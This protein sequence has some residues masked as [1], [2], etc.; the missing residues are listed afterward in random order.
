MVTRS[1]GVTNAAGV[2]VSEEAAQGPI[3]P[4]NFGTAGFVGV[5]ERGA[6]GSLLKMLGPKSVKRKVG[7]RLTGT[8]APDAVQD[9]W[10]RSSGAGIGLAVRV[11]D[12]AEE[13]AG[14]KLFGRGYGAGFIAPTTEKDN[15]SQVRIPV[16]QLTAKDGGRWAGRR[17]RISGDITI[18]SALTETTLATGVAMAKN[19]WAGATVLLRGDHTTSAAK[20]YT[21]LTN[22]VAGV[23]T[24]KSDSTM[25]TDATT[26]GVQT[27]VDYEVILDNDVLASGRRKGLSVRV[28]DG[29]KDPANEFG[30]DVYLDGEKIHGWTDL[31][32]D[33]TASNYAVDV[34][35]D[36]DSN[37]E[38]DATDL[39]PNGTSIVPDV[40]PANYYGMTVAATATK[41]TVN[42]FQIAQNDAPTKIKIASATAHAAAISGAVALVPLRLTFT[43]VAA[44]NYYTVAVSATSQDDVEV[45]NLPN[46][47]IAAAPKYNQTYTSSHPWLPIVTVDHDA[48]PTDGDQFAIDVF[49]P[50]A[51][52][53]GGLVYPDKTGAQFT[54]LAIGSV[55]YNSITVE[56]G[57]P[58]ATA[59]AATVASVTGTADE[60]FNITLGVDDAVS[61]IIDGRDQVDVTLTAGATQT[62]ADVVADIN[63]AFDAVFGAGVLNPASVSGTK[64]LLTSPG[65]FDGG[66]PGSSVE[67]VTV[68]ADAYT[69]LGLTV[70][71]TYGA[72]GTEVE[73]QYLQQASGGYDGDVPDL[74]DFLDAF[75][76]LTSPFNT[77]AEEGYGVVSILCPGIT[78]ILSAGDSATVHQRA[79]TYCETKPYQYFVE[80]PKSKTDEA[81][82]LTY[83]NTTVGRSDMAAC[84]VPS[85]AYAPD[86]DRPGALKLVS[87]TAMQLGNWA[88]LAVANAGYHVPAAGDGSRMPRVKSLP[89]GYEA[90]NEEILYP[91]GIN[92]IKK[93]GGSYVA[94]GTRTLYNNTVWRQLNNRLQMSH[95]V[96]VFVDQFDFAIFALNDKYTWGLLRAVVTDYLKKE[97][98]KRVIVIPSGGSHAFSVKI[99]EDNNPQSEIDLGIANLDIVLN[100]NKVIEQLKVSVGASGITESLA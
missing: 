14:L 75:A 73:V 52:M 65:G 45:Y 80:L 69:V 34:I 67:I 71:V 77:A 60:S 88:R 98:A 61:L 9:F 10:D 35:N 63:G 13:A 33:P 70:G 85:L 55:A 92:V 68:A 28:L 79:I 42:P 90:M 3:Q 38:F 49:P 31:S 37:L 5:F 17:R 58:S 66:G 19:E 86:P 26:G 30:L 87:T 32:M 1:Y 74:Q 95:Y 27:T 47:A 97:E 51:G 24:V 76:T 7:G 54:G 15:Q 22:D 91:A 57:D 39:L 6:P 18:S 56:S 64:V 83:L 44:S 100:F 4:G 21:V 12:G 93:R 50:D 8:M 36:D 81:D 20:E 72:E 43:W 89:T 48:D 59:T 84:Y 16:L 11:T 25:N 82:I 62:A 99:D 2:N 23:L 29:S 94:W 53:V 78:E 96:W 41:L 46:F 40:R